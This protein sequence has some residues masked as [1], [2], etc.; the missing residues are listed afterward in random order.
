M[1]VCVWFCSVLHVDALDT[2]SV[3]VATMLAEHQAAL[4]MFFLNFFSIL[5]FSVSSD[6][7][8]KVHFNQAF[9]A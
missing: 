4:A 6:L 8:L 3:A 7:L 9:A 1:C 5:Y 2:P